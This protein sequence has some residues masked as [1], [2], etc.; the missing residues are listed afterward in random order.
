MRKQCLQGQRSHTHIRKVRFISSLTS[1]GFPEAV[2]R[3]LVRT[4]FMAVELA[5]W[6]EQN[7]TH[8]DWTMRNPIRLS[9]RLNVSWSVLTFALK[10]LPE[11]S[12]KKPLA[13]L[14]HSR[15]CVRVDGERVGH[16]HLAHQDF[17]QMNRSTRVEAPCVTRGPGLA[18]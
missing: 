1:N 15:S 12:S 2:I 3:N 4:A 10:A 17:V 7:A 9:I 16:L 6:E 11:Q 8:Y 18:E 14:A 5:V 13:V